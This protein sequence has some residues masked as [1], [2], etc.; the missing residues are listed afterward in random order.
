MSKPFD[1]WTVLPH[2]DLVAL[3]E[4]L[5]TV[6]GTIEM[7]LGRFERRMTAARL[8]H[9]GLVIF[10]PVSLDDA[11]MGSLEAFGQ[12]SF[13]VVP[14]DRHRLDIKPWKDRY[15]RARV[16]APPGAVAKVAELVPVDGSTLDADDP[17]VVLVDVPGTDRHEAALLVTSADG[18]TLVLNEL[19]FNLPDRPGFG[20]WLMGVMG[21]TGDEAHMPGAIRHR[22]VKDPAAL[23]AQLEAW[24]RLPSLRRL[25]VSHGKVIDVDPAGVLSRIARELVE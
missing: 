8:A 17:S 15:P 2:G 12:P 11:R 7:P 1:Q 9:G 5:R 19:I 24:A 25:V 13:L 10:S 21:M 6:E 3:A 22:D 4:N 20:G 16:L 18:V 14:S 23:A